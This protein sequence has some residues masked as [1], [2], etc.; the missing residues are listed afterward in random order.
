MRGGHSGRHFGERE[1]KCVAERHLALALAGQAAGQLQ[2]RVRAR[3]PGQAPQEV[4][5][6]AC[7]SIHLHAHNPSHLQTQQRWLVIPKVYISE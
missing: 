1:R 5:Q 4:H 2:Q 6:C 7:L 3:R